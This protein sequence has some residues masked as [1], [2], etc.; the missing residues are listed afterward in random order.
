MR[1]TPGSAVLFIV[2]L[3]GVAV[4]TA[5]Q[6]SRP[7]AAADYGQWETLAPQPRGGLSRERELKRA[8]P[9]KGS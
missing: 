3:A 7:P 1:R 2:V 4:P 6:S 5:A 8:Q 9:R